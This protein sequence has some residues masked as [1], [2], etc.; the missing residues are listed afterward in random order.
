MVVV[1]DLGGLP[2]V[3]GLDVPPKHAE[4]G[5]GGRLHGRRGWRV[6]ILFGTAPNSILIPPQLLALRAL[7]LL[8]PGWPG[9]KQS[10]P[11]P[12]GRAWY[13][14]DVARLTCPAF[15]SLHML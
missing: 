3:P 6:A 8:R 5:R 13:S 10:F 14:N 2:G 7:A 9:L 4:E 12:S 15:V 11:W 1:L